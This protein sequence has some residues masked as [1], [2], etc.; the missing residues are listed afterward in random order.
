MV[1]QSDS[2]RNARPDSRLEVSDYCLNA[3]VYDP[4]APVLDHTP[5]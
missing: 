3:I 2:D 4:V 5:R 1:R